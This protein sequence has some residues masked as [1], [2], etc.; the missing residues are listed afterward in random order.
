[1]FNNRVKA[2]KKALKKQ[3]LRGRVVA[4]ARAEIAEKGLAVIKARDVA[5]R[6]KSALGGIYTVFADLDA[7]VLAVNQDSLDALDQIMTE[8][9]AGVDD[10]AQ[11]LAKLIEAYLSFARAEPF[12]WR[13]M[14][15]HRLP[16]GVAYPVSHYEA[17][18]RLMAHIAEPLRDLRLGESE[19]QR[20]TRARTL[21]SAFHGIIWMS[22]DDRFTGLS[23]EELESELQMMLEQLLRGARTA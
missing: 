8:A 17:L 21:F 23:S 19:A 13:A 18:A 5:D 6:A 10:P 12:L 11:K 9:V 22:L 7:I 1:V 20:F 16:E 15:E 3:D 14:F 2:L 4:A